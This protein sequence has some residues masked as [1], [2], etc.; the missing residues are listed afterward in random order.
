VAHSALLGVR[1]A[2]IIAAI[3]SGGCW[4][5]AAQIRV[6]LRGAI[7]SGPLREDVQASNR[8]SW[9]NGMAAWS[10]AVAAFCQAITSF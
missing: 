4:I 5:R 3:I 9:W 6:P 1:I 2:S 8:Q 10:A 7:L